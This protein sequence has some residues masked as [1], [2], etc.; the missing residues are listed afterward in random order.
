MILDDDDQLLTCCSGASASG[1]RLI[2]AT[3]ATLQGAGPDE[4]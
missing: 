4:E 1:C 2:G 3:T